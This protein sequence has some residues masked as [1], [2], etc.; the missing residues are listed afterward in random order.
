MAR[1]DLIGPVVFLLVGA[2]AGVCLAMLLTGQGQ[3]HLGDSTPIAFGGAIV[4]CFVGSMLRSHLS[5]NPR[6]EPLATL[7]ALALLGATVMGPMGWIAGD[8]GWLGGERG[9]DRI[10]RQGMIGGMLVGIAGGIA[11]GVIQLRSDR[12][13]QK[14]AASVKG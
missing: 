4:G 11:A 14:T 10:P 9:T 13:R 1:A 8:M 2:G 6:L 5:R 7:L 12:R 3:V